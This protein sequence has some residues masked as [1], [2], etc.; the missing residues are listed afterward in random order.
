VSDLPAS[1]S[2]PR[3]TRCRWI[4]F[5]LACAASWLL[6]LHCYAWGVIKPAS[7]K[8][9]PDL[10]DTELVTER[11][12]YGGRS[13]PESKMAEPWNQSFGSTARG[14]SAVQERPSHRGNDRC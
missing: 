3:P 8:E 6:Y 1:P 4:V 5:V 7:R 11:P 9:N 12:P 14:A 10:S 2:E 13:G